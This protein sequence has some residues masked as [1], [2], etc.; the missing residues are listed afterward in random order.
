MN[1][2]YCS[3]KYK[4]LGALQKHERKCDP[5]YFNLDVNDYGRENREYITFDNIKE[6]YENNNEKMLICKY[7]DCIYKNPDH[8]EN[9]NIKYIGKNMCLVKQNNQWNQMH[10]DLVTEKVYADAK[11]HIYN[12]VSDYKEKQIWKVL[13]NL[14]NGTIV[15]LS[16]DFLKIF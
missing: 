8:P 9:K 2:R 14:D 4:L 11:K 12:I 1:C 10:V 7:I 16:D 6:W 3:K 15:C 13:D 5:N